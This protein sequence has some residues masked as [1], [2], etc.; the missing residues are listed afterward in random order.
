MQTLHFLGTL[1]GAAIYAARCIHEPMDSLG[2]NCYFISGYFGS[3]SYYFQFPDYHLN[4]NQFNDTLGH[5]TVQIADLPWDTRPSPEGVKDWTMIE[6]EDAL[7]GSSG[8]AT[9]KGAAA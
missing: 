9:P 1:P 2:T 6:S 4:T 3:C 8:G 5:L 7:I